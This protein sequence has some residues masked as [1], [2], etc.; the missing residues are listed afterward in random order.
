MKTK[1]ANKC[2][3]EECVGKRMEKFSPK[4]VTQKENITF[5]SNY[6]FKYNWKIGCIPVKNL[7]TNALA[8]NI[9]FKLNNNPSKKQY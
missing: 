7:E 8:A 9:L 3:Y 4:P 6:T 5:K 2:D 1:Q